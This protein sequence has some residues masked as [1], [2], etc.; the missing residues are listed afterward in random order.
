MKRSTVTLPDHLAEAL[1]AYVTA[2]EVPP[3][4]TAVVQVAL[5]E[6]LIERGYLPKLQNKQL[7]ITPVKSGVTNTSIEHD[8]VLY[9]MTE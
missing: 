3:S 4:T 7:R 9:G 2:Q 6:F 1:D 8:E 5:E